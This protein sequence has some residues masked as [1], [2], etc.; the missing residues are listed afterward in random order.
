MWRRVLSVFRFIKAALC[1]GDFAVLGYLVGI[2]GALRWRLLDV[3]LH[4]FEGTLGGRKGAIFEAVQRVFSAFHY[5]LLSIGGIFGRN[6][7]I[8]ERYLV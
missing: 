5:A 1:R 3:G 4:R 8:G 6:F 7:I 2:V